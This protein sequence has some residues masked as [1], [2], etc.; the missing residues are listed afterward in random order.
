VS[1]GGQKVFCPD[2][3]AASFV[4][5]RIKW[6][7]MVGMTSTEFSYNRFAANAWYQALNV[8]LV[9][10]AQVQPGQKVVDL[11]CGPG[12]VTK[13]ILEKVR[14]AKNSVVIGIDMSSSALKQAREDLSNASNTLV[15][16]AEGRA[17]DLTRLVRDKVDTVVFCNA[18]HLVEDKS[19]VMREVSDTLRSGG[20]FAFN[21]SFFKGDL[22][23]ETSQFYRRWMMRSLRI[24]KNDF[25]LKPSKEKVMA[26]QAL[27]IA[28]YT[29][30]LEGNGFQVST[31][32]I[33]PVEVPL[34]GWQDISYFEDFIAGAL[35]GVPLKEASH[36]LVEAAA[37][38][39]SEFE[40]SSVRRDWLS[41]V[42]VRQ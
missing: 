10:L 15:E 8:H 26:R 19:Q 6:I 42:A 1:I 32:E 30:I 22:T 27:S 40:L 36:S 21:S 34:E 31:T 3:M 7:G 11:A 24:L 25:G 20:I 4:R 41:I 28:E 39:F 9:E 35:P 17:E 23:D 18:I 33:E 16:F 12:S 29:E 13:I 5:R 38:I 14:D 2:R 37:Q